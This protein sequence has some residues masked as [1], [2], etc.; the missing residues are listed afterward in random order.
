MGRRL[1][2]ALPMDFWRV[3]LRG[4]RDLGLVKFPMLLCPKRD[5]SSGD[6][7]TSRERDEQIYNAGPFAC[8]DTFSQVDSISSMKRS[9]Q[10]V[11]CRPLAFTLIEL[12]VV[13]AIVAIL[14]SL[15]LPALG[16]AKGK[17]QATECLNNLRQL[18]LAWNLYIHDHED[19]LPPIDDTEQ[20]GKDADH[21]SWVAGRLRTANEPGDKSDGTDTTLLV[22]TNYAK[23]GSIG[24]YI[25]NPAVYRCP[26]D[27][28]GRVRSMSMN[29][30]MNGRGKWQNADYVT[31][32]TL[33]EIQNPANTWVLMDER[34]DSINDGYFGV[35]MT[36]QYTIV[37]YPASYHDGSG[38]VTFAD[39]H[40]E[41]HRWQEPT[42]MPPLVSGDH[43]SPRFTFTDDR[44]MKWLTERTTVKKQ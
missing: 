42:T 35:E 37:D 39:G 9:G 1:A 18:H 21:P 28:S 23:F 19:A 22:G 34:E 3:K 26:G 43:L 29:C 38:V 6:S 44:D 41:K 33:G 11:P 5:Q 13:I 16:K 12:L 17:A 2:A 27:K 14:A 36:S 4:K 30:Y 8:I 24:G 7:P 25:Q 20:A 10:A 40:L 31:F 15:L 32:K